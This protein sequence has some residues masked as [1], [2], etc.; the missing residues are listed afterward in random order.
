MNK[1]SDKMMHLI[2]WFVIGFIVSFY[3]GSVGAGLSVGIIT[4][5]LKETLDLLIRKTG[6]NLEDLENSIIGTILGCAVY[7]I[8]F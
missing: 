3:Y 5:I 8:F 6:F 7:W 2:I 1:I 4:A